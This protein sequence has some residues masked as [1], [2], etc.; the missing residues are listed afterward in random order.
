M[1]LTKRQRAEQSYE[2]L[3]RLSPK[4]ISFLDATNP[5][6]LLVSVIMSAQTTDAQVNVVT[7]ELFRRYVDVYSLAQ[8]DISDVASII[9][10]TGYY[11]SKAKNIVQTAQI[12]VQ[13]F[14]GEVPLTM[15]EL[16]QLRGVGRKTANVILGQIANV[17]AII[18]DT[19][20]RRVVQRI[21]LTK[22]E[23]PYE[24]EKEVAELLIQEHHYRY[25]MI[26]NN[27][28][29]EYCYARKPRCFECP[30]AK[31]CESFPILS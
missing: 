18:V 29:R 31:V 16:L 20:F 8:A 27:H 1:A 10:S 6:E 3:D 24:I 28:G 7:K 22:K 14:G 13:Q 2:I 26:I 17:P 9:R 4:R 11:N 25:S 23:D 5:F 15:D 12:I 21:G 30:I 19:H